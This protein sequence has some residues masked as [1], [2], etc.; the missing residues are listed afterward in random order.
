MIRHVNMKINTA[1]KEIE[2]GVDLFGMPKEEA[3][4]ALAELQEEGKQYVT[5]CENQDEL[6]KCKGHPDVEEEPVKTID[7]LKE[8]VLLPPSPGRCQE[9]AVFHDER[10]PHNQQSLYYQM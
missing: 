6:G 3:L 5:G 1:I 9:C 8:G 7:L 2:D 4:K 10:D